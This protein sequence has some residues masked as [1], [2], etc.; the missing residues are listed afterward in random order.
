MLYPTEEEKEQQIM[1]DFWDTNEWRYYLEG[2]V[3]HEV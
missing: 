2:D 3:I 1:K